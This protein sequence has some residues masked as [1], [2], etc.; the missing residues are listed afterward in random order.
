[1]GLGSC[2]PVRPKGKAG[3]GADRTESSPL[4]GFKTM[5]NENLIKSLE[6]NISLLFAFVGSIRNESI[7]KR[8]EENALS[9]YDHICHLS[10]IQPLFY[11]RL[12]TFLKEE[13]PMISLASLRKI[14]IV[15]GNEQSI[16]TLM[17]TYESWRLRQVELV[18]STDGKLWDRMAANKELSGYSF[19]SLV[20]D[21]LL[22]DIFHI[23][24]I[25]E[26]QAI[27]GMGQP[28]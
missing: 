10:I 17:R 2:A 28:A 1:M 3:F 15:H 23:S 21:I 25:E 26:L 11:D 18:R 16:M 12:E 5:R 13:S 19:E 9:I 22:N 24:Q 4:K 6:G 14:D 7:M 27:S 8:K 20:K